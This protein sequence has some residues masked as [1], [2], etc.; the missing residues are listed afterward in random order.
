MSGFELGEADAKDATRDISNVVLVGGME[1]VG[2][3]DDDRM[4]SR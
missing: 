4:V 2:H 3:E 1:E